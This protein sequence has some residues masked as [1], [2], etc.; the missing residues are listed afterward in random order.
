M[1]FRN[2]FHQVCILVHTTCVQM[3]TFRLNIQYYVVK[4]TLPRNNNSFKL[5]RLFLKIFFCKYIV[6]CRNSFFLIFDLIM[7]SMIIHAITH[8][9]MYKAIDKLALNVQWQMSHAYQNVNVLKCYEN[10]LSC[11][12]PTRRKRYL[13]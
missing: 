7:Q 5:S 10:E 6:I 9:E 11:T 2:T 1:H 8:R 12:R 13:K 3:M 4:L